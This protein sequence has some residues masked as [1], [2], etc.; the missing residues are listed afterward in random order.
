MNH[1]DNTPALGVPT[2][3]AG[4]TSDE[5][6][7]VQPRDEI[8]PNLGMPVKDLNLFNAYWHEL[9]VMDGE[10]PRPNTP[11][12]QTDVDELY[13]MGLATMSKSPEQVR[14]ERRRR[15]GLLR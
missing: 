11:E 5:G 14:Q 10:D 4:A 8:D 7:V 1:D 15:Q 9:G 2:T 12:E 13:A 6:A 3:R